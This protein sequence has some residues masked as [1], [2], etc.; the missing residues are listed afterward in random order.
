M[1]L[2]L[3]ITSEDINFLPFMKSIIGAGH[4]TFIVDKQVGTLIEVISYCKKKNITGVIT[5]Q[6]HL[7]PKLARE[8]FDRA[9]TLDDFAGSMF[10]HADIEF[11][12]IPKLNSVVTQTYGKFLL[13]RFVSKLTQSNRWYK[14]TAFTWE[15]ANESTLE[16]L[17]NEF[18]SCIAIAIDI[19]TVEENLAIT[20]VGYCGIWIS[21][22]G[23]IRT[24]TIV[25]PCSSTY[26][27]TYIGKFNSLPMGK[28]F[29][30]GKYDISYLA[31]YNVPVINFIWDTAVMF[32]CWYSEL[33]KD[34]AFLNSFLV[35]DARYWKH[36][37]SVG[38]RDERYYLYNAHDCHNT[39]NAFMSWL[40]EAPEWAKKNYIIEMPLIPICHLAEMTGIKL[41]NDRRR[42]V[43][44]HWEK[45]INTESAELNKMLGVTFNVN[46]SKQV[47]QLK[48]IFGCEDI[49]K[50]DEKALKKCGDRHALNKFIFDKVLLI[51]Q[52]RKLVSTYLKDVGLALG[53]IHDEN[54]QR[55]LYSLNPYNTDTA[56]LA[57]KE[58]S[59][60]IG[61]N[62]QNQP[63]EEEDRIK[64]MYVADFGFHFGEADYAQAESRGTGY[65]TGDTG[66]IIAVESD[67]DFHSVNAS[68]FFGVPYESIIDPG[69]GEV[70]DKTLRDLA[71][72]TNHGANYYMMAKTL[73]DTM[74]TE[75][76]LTAKKLL[77]LPIHFTPIMIC[78]YLLKQF[79][80]TYPVVRIDYP[81]WMIATVMATRM[82]ISAGGW[83]RYCFGNPR[84]NKLNLN[85]LIAHCPQNLNAYLLNESWLRVFKEVW[86]IHWQNF[87]LNAQI[88][89]SILYQYRIG[90]EY[91]ND[92]V[93]DCMHN[94]IVV[95]DI[96]GIS[97]TMIVPV[98][99]KCGGARWSDCK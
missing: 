73:L 85:S 53:D 35:R 32:H 56:R 13:Q 87:K 55:V 23:D 16:R 49:K 42:E 30:T 59:F 75:K 25:I 77:K 86:L 29:Q 84:D 60:W 80:Q 28:I 82:L 36:E 7:I 97:R 54:K 33:P 8:T 68:K 9:P 57:S 67:K 24:H 39:A 66:L 83:T 50:G 40:I 37:A 64:E 22:V 72:R 27:L 92:M 19:E 1:N 91:L 79:E 41:D 98:D 58:H 2:L 12:M 31:R 3:L 17:Y 96:K 74:G 46:S 95:K 88:H 15:V 62:I 81:A 93:K 51:R 90:H 71:K 38:F 65:I 69:T 52:H 61:T 6:E 76:V 70:I 48:I 11:V 43:K 4:S 10:T 99:V 89:D 14:S 47:A 63:R 94:P 78:E 44:K 26:N 21:D 18:S 20:C 45:V 34:L 5:T